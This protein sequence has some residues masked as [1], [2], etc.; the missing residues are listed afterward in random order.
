MAVR[1]TARMQF[2]P[3]L[4]ADTVRAELLDVCNAGLI[5]EVM[6]FAFA[7]EQND[8]HDPLDRIQLWMDSI[9]PLKDALRAIGVES[10]LNPW[11]SILHTDRGRRF[12]PDQRWQPLVDWRGREASAMVCPLDPAWRAYYAQAM[13]L[14][15]A[16][17]FR[18]VWIDDDIR[19]HNHAPLDWGGCWCPLHIAEFNRRASAD[20]TRDDAVRHILQPGEPHPW[21]AIWFD[22]WDE[23]HTDLLASWRDIL[24]AEGTRMGLMS[25]SLEAHAMEGRRWNRWWDAI[26]KDHPPVHR[27]HFWGYSEG[28]GP[29]LLYGISQMQQHRAIRPRHV[30]SDPEIEGFPYGPWNKSF[31]YTLAQMA[32]AQVFG[33]DRLAISMFDFMGNLPSDEPERAEF[34]ARVKPL[35]AWLGDQFPASCEAHGV[36]VPWNPDMSRDVHTSGA[37]NWRQLEVGTRGWDQWLGAF[38]FAFQKTPHPTLNALAGAMPW[39]YSDQTLRG[40]LAEGVL[41]DGPAAAVLVERGMGNLIGMSNIRHITQDEILYSM[42]ESI[43]GAFGLRAGAQMSLNAEKPYAERLVQ[44]DLASGVR[45]ISV[46]RDPVQRAVGHGVYLFEN[47][48]G[49]RVAVAPWNAGAGTN[50]LHTTQGPTCQGS[51]LA[52]QRNPVRL[53]GRRRLA[54]TAVP[55]R[56]RQ[57]ARSPLECR[58][59]RRTPP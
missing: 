4:P 11:H 35:L 21:R 18:V 8:G 27:P 20:A 55:H 40:W 25:S 26:A 22:L 46:L 24:E 52:W 6:F 17:H 2:R 59:R 19:Y 51:G 54:R 5:D 31:R 45:P 10:S 44:G 12:K 23:L 39:G 16:E 50:P 42:E 37:L 36:G 1:Y 14:F 34:L 43:D 9:R 7:E 41:L 49:G 53:C 15:A 56:W 38:G 58:P 32:L 57:M 48:L 28:Q 13:R 30:E 29:V 3:D 47:A 33:S